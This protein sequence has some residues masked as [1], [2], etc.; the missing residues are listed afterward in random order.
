MPANTLPFFQ[1]DAFTDRP[2]AG[3]PA[4]V[5]PLERPLPTA[6]MQDIAAEN[7]LSETAFFYRDGDAFQLRWF[8]PTVEV[9]LCGHATLASAFV[10]MTTLEPSLTEVVFRTRSG[11]LTVRRQGELF[12]M[13]FPARPAAPAPELV[14]P[15]AAAL[16]VPLL[17]VSRSPVCAL[18]VLETAEDVR[19][20]APDLAAIARLGLT[21]CV[22]AP[23]DGQLPGVDFVSRF[24]APAHGIDEDPVTG[25][26][27]CTLA[28]YWA[29]RLGKP[30][31]RARQV[32]RRGG[33]VQVRHEPNGARV[34]ISGQ[35]ALV[36]EGTLSY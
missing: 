2:F 10:V 24:F 30:A 16:G 21:V 35:A 26:S 13:D 28:P 11:A 5:C 17:E 18:A 31:L 29:A 15:L 4:A 7:N 20:L 33:D 23:A 19:R 36:I 25:S 6:L 22:T 27:F 12:T 34:L 8:T 1:V 9:D 32:S 14:A 3:N